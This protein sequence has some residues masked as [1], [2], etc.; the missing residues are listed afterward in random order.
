MRILRL[1]S[2]II[3]LWVAA[4][5]AQPTFSQQGNFPP[6]SGGSSSLIGTVDLTN[7][8]SFGGT[9]PVHTNGF[10][11]LSGNFTVTSGANTISCTGC[12][13]TGMTGA[14]VTA[15]TWNGSDGG[16]LTSASCVSTSTA[17]TL[18]VLTATTGTLSQNATG[19]CGTTNSNVGLLVVTFDDTAIVQAAF[20]YAFNGA[21]CRTVVWP[22]AIVG[23]SDVFGNGATCPGL[24]VGSTATKY[25]GLAGFNPGNTSQVFILP[26][27]KFSDCTGGTGAD[28]VMASAAAALANIT[29]N[30][31]GVN[32]TNGNGK[33]WFT[34]TTDCLLENVIFEGLNAVAGETFSWKM[35]QSCHQANN[36]IT[37]GFGSSLPIAATGGDNPQMFSWFAGNLGGTAVITAGGYNACYSCGIQ[38]VQANSYGVQLNSGGTWI[39]YNG[40]CLT[41]NAS[42]G[43]FCYESGSTI[44]GHFFFYN[45][46]ATCNTAAGDRCVDI[47]SSG[48]ASL[49]NVNFTGGSTGPTLNCVSTAMC[50]GNGQNTL[51]GT[52]PFGGGGSFISNPTFTNCNPGSSVSPAACGNASS[53]TV[54]VPTTTATYT[55]NT[56]AVTANSRITLTPITDASGLTGS[57]TCV[58]PPTPFIAYESGRTAGT[59]FTFTLP[60]TTGASCWTYSVVD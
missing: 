3:T 48:T 21:T 55:V 30:G 16:Y 7:P 2:V 57:P 44:N 19:N 1:L 13:W 17:T 37:D 60:S 39:D 27:F 9:N 22:A 32:T 51:A 12:N 52:V 26:Y 28:C 5:F 23:I 45:S 10:A 6:S 40:N 47:Q 43:S 46:T 49:T 36:V 41:G 14:A 59:S 18:T 56:T 4:V 53:G 8:A 11:V 50:S 35:G 54:V 34:T 29:F 33:S 20:A 58:A 38:M 25:V 24:G 15:T 42:G 31:G